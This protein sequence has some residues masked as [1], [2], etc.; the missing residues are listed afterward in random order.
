MLPLKGNSF[1]RNKNPFIMRINP[2]GV[3]R[4]Q[5][6]MDCLKCVDLCVVCP[7][8]FSLTGSDGRTVMAIRVAPTW[9]FPEVGGHI[10][11]DFRWCLDMYF[12]LRIVR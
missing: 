3:T 10:Y 5:F 11:D 8:L 7:G 4:C 9:M 6:L 2:S 12:A 1:V